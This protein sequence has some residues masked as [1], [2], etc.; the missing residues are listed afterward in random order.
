MMPLTM[1]TGDTPEQRSRVFHDTILKYSETLPDFP[2]YLEWCVWH[3]SRFGSAEQPAS[4]ATRVFV[5]GLQHACTQNQWD[6][7]VPWVRRGTTKE[8]WA[9]LVAKW[10][11][12]GPG[13]IPAH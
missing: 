2:W 4:I 13:K 10:D 12:E 7:F 9:E 1:K 8:I 11:I 3:L 5:W 6:N